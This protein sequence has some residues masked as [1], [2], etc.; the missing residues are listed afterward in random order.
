[1]WFSPTLIYTLNNGRVDILNMV[2]SIVFLLSYIN[3][4]KHQTKNIFNKVFFILALLSGLQAIPMLFCGIIFINVYFKIKYKNI[5]HDLLKYFFLFCISIFLILLLFFSIGALKPFLIS[6]VSYSE[7]IKYFSSFFPSQIA[8][9]THLDINKIALY[10]NKSENIS[11]TKRLISS[12]LINSEFLILL[13]IFSVYYI[14]KL[15]IKSTISRESFFVFTFSLFIPLIMTIAGRYQLYYSWISIVPF[16]YLISTEICS[17]E[18]L[19]GRLIILMVF[20]FLSISIFKIYNSK[21]DY[22]NVQQFV[23]SFSTNLKNKKIISSFKSYYSSRELSQEV[24]CIGIYPIAYIPK[25]IKYI[26]SDG[27]D[28]LTKNG[29]N[30]YL[31][32]VNESKKNIKILSHDAKSNLTLYSID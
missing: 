2:L 25:D 13:A 29:I 11:F 16:F 8:S 14:I 1:M 27:D 30:E 3:Q 18:F 20:I 24:Y 26:I 21:T 6:I 32:L 9:M 7:T 19:K 23:N 28:L 22:N 17:F 5:I 31:L 4:A 12:Y 15:F 10:F